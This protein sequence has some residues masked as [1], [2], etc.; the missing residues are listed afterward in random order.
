LRSSTVY[1]PLLQWH[2]Y[3]RPHY[4]AD[5]LF[6]WETNYSRHRTAFPQ[7]LCRKINRELVNPGSH[8]H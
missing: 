2:F 1:L 5:R 4:T 3:W 6:N 7:I 8:D